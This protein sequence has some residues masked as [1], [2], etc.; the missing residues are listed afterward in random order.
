MRPP[1]ALPPCPAQSRDADD[2]PRHLTPALVA[3]PA[4]SGGAGFLG[5]HLLYRLIAP[6]LRLARV[7]TIIR[8]TDPVSRLPLDLQP[9]VAKRLPDGTWSKDEPIVVLGG[10]CFLPDFGLTGH[11]VRCLR[12]VDIVIHP[13]G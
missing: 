7:Y 11:D 4:R 5:S 10:D 2:A 12:E 13:A 9:F 8:G 1:L 3:L 6:P